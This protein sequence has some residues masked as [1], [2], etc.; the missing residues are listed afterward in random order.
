MQAGAFS[1]LLLGNPGGTSQALQVE[2]QDFLRGSNRD[3]LAIMPM[4][5]EGRL[6]IM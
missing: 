5:M 1:Q 6:E 3:G 4:A 2:R